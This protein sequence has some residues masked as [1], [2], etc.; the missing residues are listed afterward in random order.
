MSGMRCFGCS[1]CNYNLCDQCYMGQSSETADSPTPPAGAS[2]EDTV[3]REASDQ[4]HAESVEVQLGASLSN[5]A[6]S[7]IAGSVISKSL[8]PLPSGGADEANEMQSLQM[9]LELERQR[10]A[11]LSLELEHRTH[12]S[13]QLMRQ[14]SSAEARPKT[15]ILTPTTIVSTTTTT[16]PVPALPVV[17]RKPRLPMHKAGSLQCPP[18]VPTV[19][20]PTASPMRLSSCTL[21]RVASVLTPRPR[22][23]SGSVFASPAQRRDSKSPQAPRG[24]N[25]SL[26]TRPLFQSTSTPGRPVRSPSP[27]SARVANTSPRR[28]ITSSMRTPRKHPVV[29]S[30]RESA[31]RIA[32]RTKS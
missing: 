5:S 18:H 13:K 3:H 26:P 10:C 25:S 30:P 11:T 6:F 22:T 31:T 23:M 29:L 12:E 28:S 4:A 24:R 15:V 20:T 17:P 14:L 16:I 2:R 21:Q 1:S 7:T 9:R 19:G 27:V 8:G 32:P